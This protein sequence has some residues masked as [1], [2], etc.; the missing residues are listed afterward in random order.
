MVIDCLKYRHSLGKCKKIHI[1]T[2]NLTIYL[3]VGAMKHAAL[4]KKLGKHKVSGGSCVYI[5]RLADVDVDVLK[6]V[7]TAGYAEMKK[8]YGRNCCSAYQ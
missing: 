2:Q 6:Q 5:K 8:K 3:M 7:V 4:L 1:G